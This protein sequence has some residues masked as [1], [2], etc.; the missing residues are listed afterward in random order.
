MVKIIDK[1]ITVTYHKL[2]IT[3]SFV[4]KKNFCHDK[5]RIPIFAIYMIFWLELIESILLVVVI[6]LKK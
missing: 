1:E 3:K 2:I 6:L 4:S 5:K